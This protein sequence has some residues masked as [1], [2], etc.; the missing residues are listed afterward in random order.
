MESPR[1][2]RRLVALFDRQVTTDDALHEWG[3]AVERPV[4]GDV[5]QAVVH[6]H[7]LEVERDAGRR[8]QGRRKRQA[9]LGQPTLDS[10]HPAQLNPLPPLEFR[11]RSPTEPGTSGRAG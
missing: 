5:G 10:A 7:E 11:R 8:R 4:P 9:E 1:D 3:R 2:P 6:F